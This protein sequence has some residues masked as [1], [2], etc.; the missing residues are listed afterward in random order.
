MG[1]V[2]AARSVGARR[3]ARSEG[4]I[5]SEQGSG[6]LSQRHG[7]AQRCEPTDELEQGAERHGS[8]MVATYNDHAVLRG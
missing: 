4:G 5:G 7:R 1:N 8:E 6:T 3:T 2:S